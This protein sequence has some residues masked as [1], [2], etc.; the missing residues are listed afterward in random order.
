MEQAFGNLYEIFGRQLVRLKDQPEDMPDFVLEYCH[1]DR[2][3]VRQRPGVEPSIS[4]FSDR[5]SSVWIRSR[6]SAKAVR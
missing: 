3:W 6:R 2:C 5:R 4:G 1:G